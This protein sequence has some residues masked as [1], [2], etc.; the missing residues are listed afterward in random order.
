[1]GSLTTVAYT[2]RSY[3]ITVILATARSSV[4][5]K[6]FILRT[7]STSISLTSIPVTVSHKP[8]QLLLM[9]SLIT[10][11]TSA[12]APLFC[13][14][15]PLSL[16]NLSYPT[17]QPTGDTDTTK[18]PARRG[19]SERRG[20]WKCQEN[21]TKSPRFPLPLAQNMLPRSPYTEESC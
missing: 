6:A 10:R 9:T 15:Y 18:T 8:R 13:D 1:M 5:A 11:R 14:S 12:G 3:S 16:K 17:P 2:H 4:R 20:R 19:C 7:F 21:A